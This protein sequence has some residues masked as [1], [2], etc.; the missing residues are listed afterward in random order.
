M[1][2]SEEPIRRG[3]LFFKETL[4][5]YVKA[6][7]RYP[8]LLLVAFLSAAAFQGV[9]LTSPWF[10]REFF[11]LLAAGEKTAAALEALYGVLFVIA[12]LLALNWVI[13]RIHFYCITYLDARVMRDLYED[14][15][16]YLMR[17]SY[18]FFANQFAG[19]LTR[20]VGRFSKAF[21]TIFDGFIMQLFPAAFFIVGAAIAF[22]LRHPVIGLAFA[23]WVAVF[24]VVQMALVRRNNP[25]RAARA[26]EDSRLT[27]AVADA[28]GNQNTVAVFAGNAHEDDRLR[29]TAGRWHAAVLRIWNADELAWGV[30]GFLMLCVN[31]GLLYGAFHYWT[32]GVLTLGDFVLIQ[33]YLL[34]TFERLYAVNREI[35]SFSEA[36]AD[37]GEMVEILETKHEIADAPNAGTLSVP[38]G[39]IEFEKVRFSFNEGRPVLPDF[40]LAIEG[41]ERVALV[42]PSGAGKTT[43]TKLLLRLHDVTD[44]RILIDGQDIRSVT[45][46]SLR[47]AIGFVP[48]EPILFHRTLLENIRYGKRDASDA[49]VRRA[50]KEAHCLEFIERTQHGFQTY[51]G[52]RGVKLSGGERQRIAIARAILKDAPILVLDEA[53]S[54]LDSESEA[55]IQDAL[56]RL[57]RGKTVIAIA[58]RLSTVMRMDRIIVIE[59]G[60]VATTGTHEELVRH[61]GGL[62]KKLWEIQAGGFLTDDTTHRA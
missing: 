33:A 49:E 54:S 8:W 61:N 12:G 30:Q 47:E 44:G 18:R 48:Q 59:D 20:R 13:A 5:I 7:A 37:A 42:G 3:S 16:T 31:I 43:I 23:T 19:T 55:L 52:E 40:S 6:A 56:A 53:T 29:S 21:E 27:G 24:V 39:K 17:H 9:M 1:S 10:M 46:D 34:T 50:A 41:G 36:F 25:L 14:A 35:R 38:E 32:E 15:F 45:Q 2:M 58:H 4:R 60:K 62:Y 11:N 57:M 51:V 28:I 26:E 22:Y